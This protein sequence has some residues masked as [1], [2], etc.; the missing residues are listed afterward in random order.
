MGEDATKNREDLRQTIQA[1]L[2]DATLKQGTASRELRQEVSD[3]TKKLQDALIHMAGD[4]RTA[5]TEQFGTL[6]QRLSDG[7]VEV[8]RR[9]EET[10]SAMSQQQRERLESV[11]ASLNGLSDRHE[12]TQQ[13]LRQTVEQRLDAIRVESAGKLDEIRRAVDEQLQAALTDR[14]TNSFKMVHDQLE[15]VYRGLGE[16]QK[17]AEGVGDLKRV[18]TNVKARG[19]FGE[20]QLGSLIEQMFSPDQYVENAQVREY[21]QERVEFAV[22]IPGR[23]GE[24]DVLLPLDAKFPIEDYERII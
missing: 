6:A 2:G 8:T 10:L 9:S 7:L 14:I 19:V 1:K 16:M 3:T 15:Q 22:K 18:L 21:S 4:Q 5:Q 12:S 20:V 11:I 24:G 13:S 23:S 17:L